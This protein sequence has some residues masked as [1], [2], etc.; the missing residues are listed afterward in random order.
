MAAAVVVIS[1]LVV[2]ENVQRGELDRDPGAFLEFLVQGMIEALIAPVFAL[3]AALIISNQ[4]RNVVGWLLMIPALGAAI[5]DPLSLWIASFET[6]PASLDPVL[7]LALWAESWSWLLFIFPIFHLLQVFPTGRVLTPRWRWLAYLEV[8]MFVVFVALVTFSDVIGPS[9]DEEVTWTLA[10]PIG[11]IPPTVWESGFSGAWTLGLLVLVIGG[12]ASTVVRFR[13]AQGT[14]RQQ[15]K[16][17]LYALVFFAAVYASTAITVETFQTNVVLDVLFLLSVA[18]IPVAMTL[19]VLRYR[20]FDIDL[21]IRKTLVYGLLTGLLTAVYFGSVVLLQSVFRGEG[22]NSLTVAA[23]TLLITALFAPLR[24]RIQTLIDRRLFRSKYNAQVVIERFGG[25]AQSQANL[26]TLSA[27]LMAV[28]EE[29]IQPQ[30]GV[31]WIRQPAE[32][33]ARAR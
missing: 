29:T 12:G 9:S 10:N 31:L 30:S 5:I 26:E 6:A 13:R 2:I 24:R 33:T 20:L 32:T 8:G 21:I 16:F 4:P 25:A 11:F 28:V 27:D 23:S 1:I 14:E 19:A 3:L 17:L 7:F 22:S 15:L 18:A